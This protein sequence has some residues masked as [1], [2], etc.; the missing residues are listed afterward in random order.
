MV[1]DRIAYDNYIRGPKGFLRL[2]E[3][4]ARNGVIVF[5]EA[6]EFSLDGL[7]LAGSSDPDWRAIWRRL[8]A[9]PWAADAAAL[10]LGTEPEFFELSREELAAVEREAAVLEQKWHEGS[11]APTNRTSRHFFLDARRGKARRVCL[12]SKNGRDAAEMESFLQTGTAGEFGGASPRSC[13]A[14]TTSPSS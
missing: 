9:K 14:A 11:V 6:V 3:D 5:E 8:R 2:F 1:R 13:A 10:E 4:V 7:L 12:L